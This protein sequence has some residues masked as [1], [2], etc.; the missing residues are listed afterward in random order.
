MPRFR[1]L[2]NES[3]RPQDDDVAG[4]PV[5]TPSSYR[6]GP[7][8]QLKKNDYWIGRKFY[9]DTINMDDEL[10]VVTDIEPPYVKY[11]AL[12]HGGLYSRFDTN[13]ERVCV[14]RWADE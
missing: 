8:L 7:F 3:D 11:T 13:F 9:T 12:R 2:T 14:K 6:T 4:A 1:P 5:A 10:C